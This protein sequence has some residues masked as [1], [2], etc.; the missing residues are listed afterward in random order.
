[1]STASPLNFQVAVD[2]A[3]ADLQTARATKANVERQ[4][5]EQADI[6][7]A[8]EATGTPLFVA[9]ARTSRTI[10]ALH[11]VL[12]DRLAPQSQLHGVLVD[13]YGVGIL[14]LGKSGIGKSEC[15]LESGCSRP[16]PR[17]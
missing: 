3:T 9:D 13:V 2:S 17:G 6:V 8:A 5:G 4:L 7:T 16:W 12:D 10:N 11:S 15:A 14:L 1:M